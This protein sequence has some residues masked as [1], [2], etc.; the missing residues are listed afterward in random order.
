M[1]RV[2]I[3]NMHSLDIPKNEPTDCLRSLLLL[4][5]IDCIALPMC[6]GCRETLGLIPVDTKGIEA[7]ITITESPALVCNAN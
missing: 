4:F 5:S 3:C 2:L 1:S 6:N 7:T